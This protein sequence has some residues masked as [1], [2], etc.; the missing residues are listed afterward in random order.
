MTGTAK[1]Y[2]F[3]GHVLDLT[4]G[5]LTR[6]GQEIPLRPRSFELL[7]L[8][9]DN[10]GRL[11]DR[12]SINAAV[13]PDTVT[14]DENIAQCVREVRLAIGDRARSVVRTVPRRGYVLTASVTKA[15]RDERGTIPPSLARA[16]GPTIIVPPFAGVGH[17]PALADRG[18]QL[19]DEVRTALSR[20][21]SVTVIESGP[22]HVSIGADD[23]IPT[24]HAEYVLSGRIIQ[25]G[26]PP[27]VTVQL[28]DRATSAHIWASR[29]DLRPAPAG[30]AFG[31]LGDRIAI[32]IEHHIGVRAL[33]RGRLGQSSEP[34]P[35]DLLLR[36]REYN[37]NGPREELPV[38]EALIARAIDLEPRLAAAHAQMASICYAD[39]TWQMRPELADRLLGKGFNSAERALGLNPSLPFANLVVGRLHL[40]AGEYG[41]A[42]RW[43]HHARDLNRYDGECHADV[44]NI[45]SYMGRSEEAL[46]HLT[47]ARELSPIH[48]P[49]WDYYMGRALVHLGRH[50][51]A[52]RWLRRAMRRAPSIRTWRGYHAAA[53]AHLGRFDELRVAAPDR[54]LPRGSATISML[55]RHDSYLAGPEL[56]V[57]TEGLRMAGFPE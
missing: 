50:A 14:T 16:P 55:V 41:E 4:R 44:A 13:W 42:L 38:A 20:L 53:L 9:I 2:R 47:R 57:L 11:L 7:R 54:R 43:A 49:L 51:E 10:P 33:T 29:Y 3:E 39:M 18:E 25:S 19:G 15:E 37:R 23:P 56:D 40:R 28:I 35:Y 1:T 27:R 46:H 45:L 24:V 8:M 17:A 22:G 48:D 34:T 12:D 36:G 52:I 6:N 31:G 32:S 5:V 30:D 26:Q 21:T